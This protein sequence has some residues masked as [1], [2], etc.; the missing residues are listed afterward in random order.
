[1]TSTDRTHYRELV[2][3]VAEKAK[4]KLPQAVNGRIEKAVALVLQGDVEPPAAD[5]SITVYSGTDA[6]RRYVLHGTGCTCADFERGQ[7]PQGWCCHRIAAGIQKRVA[8]LLPPALESGQEVYPMSTPLPEA[9][10]SLNVKV[11]VQGH[12]VQVTLRGTDEAA[13]LGRL[14]A[15]LTRQDIRPIPKPAP[16]TGGWQ[17]RR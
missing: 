4:A 17:K 9:P 14:Q 8:E 10:A 16:R 13:L 6:T 12:E 5:G 3:Q 15:L 1:M 2:A 7:A 11:L